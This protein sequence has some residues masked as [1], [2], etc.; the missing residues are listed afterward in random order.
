MIFPSKTRAKFNPRLP[1]PC[2]LMSVAEDARFTQSEL[3]F[4]Q[5]RKALLEAETY[6]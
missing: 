1:F 3:L 5:T 2:V 6:K 4:N